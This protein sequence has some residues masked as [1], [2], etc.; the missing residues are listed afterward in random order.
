MNHTSVISNP[1]TRFA[2]FKLVINKEQWSRIVGLN[3]EEL[4]VNLREVK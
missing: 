4:A 2:P 1:I 3:R